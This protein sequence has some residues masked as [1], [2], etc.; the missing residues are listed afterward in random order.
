M[1]GSSLSFA[2]LAAGNIAAYLLFEVS[3]PV[4]VAA[5]ALLSAEAG[6]TVT[7]RE[8]YPWTV[9]RNSILAAASPELHRDL[10]ELIIATG[11]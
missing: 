2:Y 7:D 1:L 10:L 3:S 4:H 8:G 9:D 11:G 5:G 6:A